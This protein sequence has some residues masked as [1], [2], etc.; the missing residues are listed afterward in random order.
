[1]GQEMISKGVR[2]VYE[3]WH[4]KKNEIVSVTISVWQIQQINYDRLQSSSLLS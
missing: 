2:P 3:V 1:M 4:K